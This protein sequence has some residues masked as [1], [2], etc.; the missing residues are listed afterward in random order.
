MHHFITFGSKGFYDACKRIHKQADDLNLFDKFH[1]YYDTDLKNDSQFWNEHSNF[2]ENNP[3]GYGY[4][5]W[6]PYIIFKT[7]L[8]IKEGDTILYCDSGCEIDLRKKNKILHLINTVKKDL[9]VCGIPGYKTPNIPLLQEKRWVKQDLVYF[10]EL[11]SN[12][13]ILNSQQRNA[14]ILLLHKT[15]KTMEFIEKWYKLS[16]NYHF[17][18][19][20]PSIIPNDP[21]FRENRHDQSVF[22]LLVKKEDLVS[23]V[24]V[25][26]AI[27]ILRNRGLRSMLT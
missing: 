19:D 7:M 3:R 27:D 26:D 1:I 18:D 2:I 8:Q 10:L 13:K 9:L 15:P 14:A 24:M 12:Y 25:N 4:W 16:C 11:E 6:K 20:S 5:L 21:L 17:I 22:S 23:K